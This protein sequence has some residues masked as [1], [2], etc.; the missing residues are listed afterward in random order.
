MCKPGT[1][2]VFTGLGLFVLAFHVVVFL[3]FLFTFLYVLNVIKPT[4]GELGSFTTYSVIE[5]TRDITFLTSVAVAI[6]CFMTFVFGNIYLLT[7]T[8]F[9]RSVLPTQ[10]AKQSNWLS[11]SLRVCF[12]IFFAVI[13]SKPIEVILV[14][15]NESIDQAV[16]QHKIELIAQMFPPEKPES[17]NKDALVREKIMSTINSSNFFLYKVKL[18][19]TNSKYSWTWL[20]SILFIAMF[21][22]PIAVKNSLRIDSDYYRRMK[23]TQRRIIQNSYTEFKSHFLQLSIIQLGKQMEFYEAFEDPPFNTIRKTDKRTF[24]KQEDFLNLFK[25]NAN[26]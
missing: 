12:L 5:E 2:L 1:R 13:I 23:I 26:A 25:R 8:T 11:A 4:I 9:T 17:G 24:K 14:Q 20:L 21:V 22:L 18:I 7:I 3:G 6:A 15:G 10:G 16:L 19:S